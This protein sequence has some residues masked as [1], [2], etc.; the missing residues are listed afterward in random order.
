M[1]F[2]SQ[3]CHTSNIDSTNN[4]NFNNNTENKNNSKLGIQVSI[5]LPKKY[6]I[7]RKKSY[8]IQSLM[9]INEIK[10]S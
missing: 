10:I 2:K 8:P 6:N 9:E 3:N 1:K 5:A 7:Y 4:Y